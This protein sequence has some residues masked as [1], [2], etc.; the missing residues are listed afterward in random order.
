MSCLNLSSASRYWIDQHINLIKCRFISPCRS[1]ICKKEKMWQQ[2]VNKVRAT[3]DIE[4]EAEAGDSPSRPTT[5]VNVNVYDMVSIY[6]VYSL[7]NWTFAYFGLS[8]EVL[9]YR[10]LEIQRNYLRNCLS[11]TYLWTYF[12]KFR[13]LWMQEYLADFF[14]HEHFTL[15]RIYN[16]KMI[17]Y[18]LLLKLRA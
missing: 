5:P 4:R 8:P 7:C 15:L 13:H 14:Y 6:Y 10:D 9:G 18:C 11:I 3:L 2:L 1:F 12:T 16:F 17:C